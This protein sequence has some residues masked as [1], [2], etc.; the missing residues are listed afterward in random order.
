[1]SLTSFF[2]RLF[3]RSPDKVSSEEM[4]WTE[5]K[6]PEDIEPI[7][8]KILNAFAGKADPLRGEEALAEFLA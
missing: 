7:D 6:V 4:L 3:H 5:L 2:R 8:K 1:M